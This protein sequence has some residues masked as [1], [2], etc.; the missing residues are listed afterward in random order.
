MNDGM[1]RKARVVNPPKGG[2][3]NVPNSQYKVDPPQNS[4]QQKQREI[5]LLDQTR[6]HVHVNRRYQSAPYNRATLANAI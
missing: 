6:L 1:S 3:E 4:K 5:T 2:T